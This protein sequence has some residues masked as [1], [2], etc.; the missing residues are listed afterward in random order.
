MTSA[1]GTDPG[2]A[3][4]AADFF[5]GLL[6]CLFVDIEQCDLGAFAGIAGGDR[7]TDAGRGTRDNSNMVFEQGHEI[8]LGVSLKLTMFG[9]D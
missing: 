4:G 9:T 2:L 1:S 7:A 6:G 3:T 8:F 5:R